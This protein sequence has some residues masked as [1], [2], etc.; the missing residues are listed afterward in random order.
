MAHHADPRELHE[1]GDPAEH[2]V[3]EVQH[4]HQPRQ[5]DEVA[6]ARVQAVRADEHDD[7][8]DDDRAR[9]EAV[10]LFDRLVPRPDADEVVR[11]AVR[12]VRATEPGVGQPDRGAGHDDDREQHEVQQRETAERAW[13]Q[14]GNAH[15]P[16][17]YGRLPRVIRPGGSSR[18]GVRN[19]PV[20]VGTMHPMRR[21]IMVSIFAVFVIAGAVAATYL[22]WTEDDDNG[23]VAVGEC[24]DRARSRRRNRRRD[25][26]GRDDDHD[27]PARQ[28]P[29]GDDRLRRATSTSRASSATSSPRIRPRCSRRSRPCSDRPT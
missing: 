23:G 4:E 8:R 17:V 27:Q 11:V 24:H 28:R 2:G 14:L 22:L 10:D 21:R 15:R 13:R 20:R 1:H 7:D 25:D 18:P 5:P 26:C 29:T 3:A 16:R 9:E 6:P 12:P 19:S